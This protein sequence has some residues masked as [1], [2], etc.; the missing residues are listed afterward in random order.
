M[1]ALI[2]CDEMKNKKVNYKIKIRNSCFHRPKS[3]NFTKLKKKRE[4]FVIRFSDYIS[5]RAI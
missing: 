3:K 1:G 4:Y 5:V 2:L